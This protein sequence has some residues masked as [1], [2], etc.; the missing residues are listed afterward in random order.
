MTKPRQRTIGFALTGLMA[1]AIAMLG[2]GAFVFKSKPAVA[3]YDQTYP[4]YSCGSCSTA[5]GSWGQEGCDFRSGDSYGY[6]LTYGAG[7]YSD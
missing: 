3:C 2:A 1:A 6:C 7:C 5:G 4:V